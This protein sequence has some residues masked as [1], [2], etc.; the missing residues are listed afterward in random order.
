VLAISIVV[1]GALATWYARPLAER[2]GPAETGAGLL[3]FPLLVLVCLV[4]MRK[5]IA[6]WRAFKPELHWWHLLWFLVLASGFVWRVRDAS[7]ARQDPADPAALA[8]VGLIGLVALALTA[9]LALKKPDWLH[10]LFY[11]LTGAM[12]MFALAGIASTIW[13]VNPPWTLY[14]SIEFLIDIALMAAILATVRTPK[15]YESLLNWNWILCG[16]LLLSAWVSAAIVPEEGLFEGYSH[17][18]LGFRLAGVYPG[19]GSN[20]LGDLG[21]ILGVIC[22]SRIFPLP[23]RRYD[24]FWY[25]LVL[26]FCIGTIVASQ[27]RTAVIGLLIGTALIFIL[28]R[29]IGRL[30]LGACCIAGIAIIG[31]GSSS[32]MEFVQRGQSETELLTL[33]DRITWWTAALDMFRG[34]PWTGLGAFAAGSFAVFDKLGMNS[35]GPLHSDYI[36]T[37]VGTSF[38]GLL[39]LIVAIL[40]TWW[41]LVKSFRDPLMDD[42]ERQLCMEVIAVFT[43]ISIRSVFMTFITMH[44]PLNFMVLL[45]YAEL[46]RRR[47]RALGA[48]VPSSSQAVEV[49]SA[50]PA[51]S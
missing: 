12:T 50:V 8:R 18:T 27:T 40:G 19:Q 31:H 37:L 29:R 15:E 34:H 17:G 49:P 3:A 22:L 48:R 25:T 21:A 28:T 24:R 33:S 36:E 30:I 2:F 39:P 51:I 16:L 32:F 20:R 10:S 6:K 42:A 7:N 1:L 45:G 23:K 4:A 35:V 41:V 9:R 26:L 13:S 43:V 14:K 11:G 44:P 47:R 5:V 38:W 46:L